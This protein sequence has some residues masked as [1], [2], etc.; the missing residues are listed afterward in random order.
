MLHAHAYRQ[1]PQGSVEVFMFSVERLL[2]NKG[3]LTKNIDMNKNI[4]YQARDK[5]DK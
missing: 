1:G 2:R 3:T 4:G 5:G